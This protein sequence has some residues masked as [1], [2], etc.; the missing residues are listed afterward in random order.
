M[1]T[2][3]GQIKV[4]PKTIGA[5][6]KDKGLWV[7]LNQR[8]Y[9][10][11]K[12]HINDLLKDFKLAI[13]NR[14]PEYFLDSIVVIVDKKHKNSMV[15]DGQQRLA[16]AMILLAAIRDYL[17]S[18]EDEEGANL[19]NNDFISSKERRSRLIKPHL[20]LNDIDHNYF[21]NHILRF[22]IDKAAK[23]AAKHVKDLLVGE[24]ADNHETILGEWTDFIEDSAKVMWVEVPDE[25]SAYKI[26]ETM[27]EHHKKKRRKTSG[28]SYFYR[29][30]SE[31]NYIAFR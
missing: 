7:P 8:D 1:V 29:V 13:R 4:T 31:S 5:A 20:K 19:I 30:F 21:E 16:T 12:E 25:S 27:E 6:L 3:I 17:L 26:F 23:I 18:T 9:A 14:L 2:E 24:K 22:P 28:L 11:G 15:V 10:W